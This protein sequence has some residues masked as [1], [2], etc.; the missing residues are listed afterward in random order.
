[1]EEGPPPPVLDCLE[2]WVMMPVDESELSA[3]RDALALR[4]HVHAL[5]PAAALDDNG[6]LRVGEAWVALPPVEARLVACLLDRR[7]AVVSRSAL[8]Q[9]GWPDAAPG[10][11]ALDVHV[12]RLRRRLASVGL[13]VRTVRSRGYLLEPSQPLSVPRPGMA[14]G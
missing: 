14:T 7:G 3:R 1:V 13:A 8:A 10:R 5:G 11:N 2:D 4:V 6:I 9:A 12:L